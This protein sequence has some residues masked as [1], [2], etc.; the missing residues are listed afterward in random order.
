MRT[1]VYVDGFNLFY[2]SLKGRPY[3]WLDLGAFFDRTLPPGHR[4]EVVKYFTARVSALPHD[5]DAPARQAVYLRALKAHMGARLHIIEGHFKVKRARAPL[6]APPHRT[7]EILKTEEK[8]SDV[9]LAVEMVNDAWLDVCD[10]VAVVSND[11]DLEHAMRIVKHQ[12]KK[13][14]VLYTPGAPL[15]RPLN[16][17]NRWAHKQID[18]MEV[19]LAACQLPPTIPDGTVQLV[20]PRTW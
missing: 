17:L 11:G 4:L 16:A 14:V 1:V 8:G 3:R 9:N 6:S 7:V 12:R 5:P 15:R 19:D 2:G 18:V 10:C 13:H 20:K